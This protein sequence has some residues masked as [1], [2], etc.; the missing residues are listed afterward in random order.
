MCVSVCARVPVCACVS[1]CWCV[2]AGVCV[3]VTQSVCVCSRS[4]T[5]L[6]H[7][8]VYAWAFVFVFIVKSG[9]WFVLGGGNVRSNFLGFF[10]CHGLHLHQCWCLRV[11]QCWHLPPRHSAHACNPND[12]K[13]PIKN[14]QTLPLLTPARARVSADLCVPAGLWVR[15]GSSDYLAYRSA[16]ECK[17]KWD[18]RCVCTDTFYYMCVYVLILEMGRK[19]CVFSLVS[20]SVHRTY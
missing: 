11:Y 9:P 16:R 4:S 12:L 10:Q 7:T 1:L 18:A 5:S 15:A 19:V 6:R 20:A 3:N 13:A 2:R 14:L 8:C 17:W